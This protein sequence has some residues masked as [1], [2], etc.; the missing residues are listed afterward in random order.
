MNHFDVLIKEIALLFKKNDWQLVTAE[1]CTGGLIAS[2][3]T[4][5]PGSSV[6]FERGFV[7]YSNLAKQEMLGVPKEL[8]EEFGAVSE[9][10]ASA[11]ATGA[12]QHSMGDIGLS[13]TGIAGPDGGTVDKP[14]GTVWFAWATREGSIHTLKKQFMGTRQ[15]IRLTSCHEALQGVLTTIR[16]IQL[17]RD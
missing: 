1:S 17:I 2:Y 5:L 10:V 11:M 6:W 14:V 3:I 12:L 15:E 16:N 7:T 9:E 13:V 4:E 8:I